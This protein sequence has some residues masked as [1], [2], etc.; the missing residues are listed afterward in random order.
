MGKVLSRK[1]REHLRCHLESDGE[2][3][4]VKTFDSLTPDF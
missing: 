4:Q 1:R 3:I 2:T